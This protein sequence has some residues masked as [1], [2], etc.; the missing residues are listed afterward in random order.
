MPR[1]PDVHPI[2]GVWS[3]IGLVSVFWAR[4]YLP[5]LPE[6]L[7]VCPSRMLFNIR[8]VGCGSATALVALAHF[9]VLDAI[10]ANPLFVVGGIL[11][12]TW[13]MIAAVGYFIGKPLPKWATTEKRKSI[14]RFV[15]IGAV[16]GNWAYELF[17]RG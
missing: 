16:I 10:V 4:F 17:V 6:K 12:G 11:L 8:C 15:L 14:Q 9:Q 2:H 1:S 7:L 5:R 13:G 3:L